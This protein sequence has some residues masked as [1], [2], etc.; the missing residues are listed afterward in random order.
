VSLER[1]LLSR[2][3]MWLIRLLPNVVS[4]DHKLHAST[5]G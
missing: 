4:Q 5:A 3:V 1:V 2:I